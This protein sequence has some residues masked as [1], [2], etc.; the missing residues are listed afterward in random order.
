MANF[1]DGPNFYSLLIGWARKFGSLLILIE[2]HVAIVGEYFKH[3]YM[4]TNLVARGKNVQLE[5]ELQLAT[6]KLPFS[7]NYM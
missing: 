6:W 4:A 5:L 3:V 1:E 7:L 2:C